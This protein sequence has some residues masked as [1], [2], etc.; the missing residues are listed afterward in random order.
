M[1]STICCAMLAALIACPVYA[2]DATPT[3]ADAGPSIQ[4][5]ASDGEV[6]I[7]LT[8]SRRITGELDNVSQVVLQTKFG[9]AN[10]PLTEVDG[11]KL[12]I[13]ENDSAVV[14]FKN[15][16]VVTGLLKMDALAVST[17]WGGANVKLASVE[18]ILMTKSGSFYQDSA[19]G[20]NRWRFG[21]TRELANTT[22]RQQQG[23]QRQGFQP[24]TRPNSTRQPNRFGG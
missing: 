2:Q 14:A 4:S 18:T 7:E 6:V 5:N 19:D 8:K 16:D 10:I 13:D 17:D 24:Q 22:R 15:G 3:A 1:K 20:K 12:H 21:D 23:T 9:E 11:I